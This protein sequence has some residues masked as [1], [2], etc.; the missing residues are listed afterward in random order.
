M[1]ADVFNPLDQLHAL[2][3]QLY[4]IL[5]ELTQPIIV[6]GGQS[7]SY[8]IDYF[9]EEIGAEVQPRAASVDID[10]V[11]KKFDAEQLCDQWNVGITVAGGQV[12]PPS[13]AIALLIDK[14]NEKI[15]EVDGLQF[16]DVDTYNDDGELKPN[17]VDFIDAPSGFAI[18]DL[19]NPVKRALY[20]TCYQFN[21]D[22]G[23]QSHENLLILSP[24]GCLI[25][26]ISNIFLTPKNKEIEIVCIKDLLYPLYYYIQEISHDY[27]FRYTKDR[28][29]L[30]KKY[31]LRDHAVLLF[32]HYDVDLRPVFFE[33]MAKCP[34]LPK[35]FY[36]KEMPRIVDTINDKYDRRLHDKQRREQEHAEKIARLS[37]VAIK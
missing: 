5:D 26:R 19:Q 18:A 36:D 23:I 9:R 35:N 28:I 31:L 11:A 21:I 20:T 27:N 10:Y 25:S 15:K 1:D 32:T 2:N 34:G 24:I 8:W 29:D 12:P 6:V 3:A 33:S 4:P 37:R 16:I 22:T 7:V 13:V 30:L 17:V 14:D